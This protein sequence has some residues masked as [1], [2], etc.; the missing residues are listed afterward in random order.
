MWVSNFL[1]SDELLKLK[2]PKTKD[3]IVSQYSQKL[4][5]RS[6]KRKKNTENTEN[7]ENTEK[8][9]EKIEK[10]ENKKKSEANFID[11]IINKVKEIF[12]S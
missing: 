8:T 2:R 11:K 7:K 5:R 10:K 12:F 3:S 1:S 9:E 4:M 6:P